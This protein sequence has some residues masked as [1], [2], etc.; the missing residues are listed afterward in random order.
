MSTSRTDPERAI[1]LYSDSDDSDSSDSSDTDDDDDDSDYDPRRNEIT[2]SRNARNRKRKSYA[3]ATVKKST[4]KRFVKGS[5]SSSDTNEED[6]EEVA[7][8]SMA[9]QSRYRPS[10]IQNKNNAFQ[11]NDSSEDDSEDACL[12]V[13]T[14][15]VNAIA[16]FPH[17]RE[18]CVVYPRSTSW[19]GRE[20]LRYCDKCYCYVCDVPAKHCRRWNDHCRARAKSKKMAR[21]KGEALGKE[22]EEEI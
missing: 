21:R 17:A 13:G 19:N 7:I 18:D 6:D 10:R 15:G 5:G 1:L 11:T 16:D 2:S 3:A 4:T 14:N 8:V 20:N 22:K 12:L 9:K